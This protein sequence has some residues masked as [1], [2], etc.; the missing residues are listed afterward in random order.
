VHGA[1]AVIIGIIGIGLLITAF[2]RYCPL[3]PPLKIS[4]VKKPK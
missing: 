4:T 3:Y 1:L 2:V